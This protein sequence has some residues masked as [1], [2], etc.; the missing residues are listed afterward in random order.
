VRS[1][2]KPRLNGRLQLTQREVQETRQTSPS[3]RQTQTTVLRPDINGGL[4]ATD[5]INETVQEK[6][7]GVTVVNRTHLLP[8]GNRRW[9]LYETREQVIREDKAEVRV[10]EEVHRRD[11][12]RRLSLTERTVTREWKDAKGEEHQT[13]EV[14]SNNIGGTTRTE[15]GRLVL[16][17]RLST[18]RRSLPDGSQQTTQEFEQRSLVSPTEPLRVVE[19]SMQFS[20][21]VG[22]G[23]TQVQKTV[24]TLDGGGHYRTTIVLAGKK[25]TPQAPEAPP[26]EE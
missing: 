4:A 22:R 7:A 20:R 10:E 19:K 23:E 14:F 1:V 6:G 5:Q 24:Q 16:D 21:P 2:S 9:E 8:D 25:P 3:V 15:D 17:H 26:K 11:A 12:N 18:V 13:I